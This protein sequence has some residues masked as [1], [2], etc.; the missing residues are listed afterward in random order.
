MRLDVYSF[1]TI[2]TINDYKVS[3][4]GSW[5]ERRIQHSL[6]AANYVKAD[7]A[8]TSM[9]IYHLDEQQCWTLS[10]IKLPPCGDE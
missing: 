4:Q 8:T 10:K 1:P 6:T 5:F 3:A 7:I 2:V 9:H